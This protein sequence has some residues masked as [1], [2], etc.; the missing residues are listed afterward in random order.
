MKTSWDKSCFKGTPLAQDA[1]AD[2]LL[3]ECSLHVQL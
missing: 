3:P 2:A 1:F